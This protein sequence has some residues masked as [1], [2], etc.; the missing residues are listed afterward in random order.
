VDNRWLPSDNPHFFLFAVSL[1]TD[2]Y[3][4]SPGVICK[5]SNRYFV[6]VPIGEL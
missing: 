2:N 5:Q 1:T 6:A 3:V 4:K